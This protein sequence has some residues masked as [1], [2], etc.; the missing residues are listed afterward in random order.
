[1]VTGD[2][3]VRFLACLL[4]IFFLAS[5]RGQ[6][7]SADGL[8]TFRSAVPMSS[9][10]VGS[11][12]QFRVSWAN[13]L[14]DLDSV[15]VVFSLPVSLVKGSGWQEV[16][17]ISGDCKSVVYSGTFPSGTSSSMVVSVT[18]PPA[19]GSYSFV[20]SIR[21]RGLEIGRV[22]RGF[23]VSDSGSVDWPVFLLVLCG[24]FSSCFFGFVSVFYAV[25]GLH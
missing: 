17:P 3:P 4:L 23:S 10:R 22:S 1:M 11:A 5:C 16:S 24:F 6:V 14:V 13:G 25:R 19:A 2:L 12:V 20:A 21:Y 18:A 15:E 7:A 8:M 9:Y